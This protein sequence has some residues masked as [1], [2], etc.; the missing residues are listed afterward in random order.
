[1]K[2]KNQR[3]AKPKLTTSDIDF[4]TAGDILQDDL[5]IREILNSG[6]FRPSNAMH[7][8]TKSAFTEL[9][10]CLR[11]LLH[12]TDTYGTRISFTDDIVV[13]PQ[14]KDITALVNFIRDALCHLH[15]YHHWVVPDRIKASFIVL[16]GK[17]THAPFLPDHDIVL[18]S[19]YAD[20]TCFFFGLQK[21]YLRRHILRAFAEAK[22]QL[23]PLPEFPNDILN[24]GPPK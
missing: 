1:M 20:D 21:I 11:D 14:T 2:Q 5:R 13:T 15:I 12:K 7:P 17:R 8:L 10:V 9:M 19:E 4:F 23:F 18:V 3:D 24:Y 16:Y 6:I 22:M